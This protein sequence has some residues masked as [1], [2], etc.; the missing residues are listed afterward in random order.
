VVA[1]DGA[2]IETFAANF[3]GELIQ[4]Q[5]PG[6]DTPRQIWNGHV[7]RRPALIARCRGAA[8]VMAVVRF[9]REHDWAGLDVRWE[10]PD[11]EGLAMRRPSC[12]GRVRPRQT[13]LDSCT[14]A[15]RGRRIESSPDTDLMP[16][17]RC[18]STV[19][20][21]SHAAIR[22]ARTSAAPTVRAP[23]ARRR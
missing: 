14:A 2:I 16:D 19:R 20:T 8:D 11:R 21:L 17:R 13:V 4:P 23:P 5:E 9:C 18:R 6:C 3:A 7:Q 12:G 22:P 10:K 1:I 15:R